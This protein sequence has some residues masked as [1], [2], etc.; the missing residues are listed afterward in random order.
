LVLLSYSR[1]KNY[2]QIQHDERT[3][4]LEDIHTTNTVISASRR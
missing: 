3:V 2:L 4:S 1:D